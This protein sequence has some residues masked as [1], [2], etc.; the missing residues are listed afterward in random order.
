MSYPPSWARRTRR[1]TSI[2]LGLSLLTTPAVAQLCDPGAMPPAAVF[3]DTL[4]LPAPDWSLTPFYPVGG[5]HLDAV[6]NAYY[7]PQTEFTYFGLAA[8]FD[9]QEEDP[10]HYFLPEGWRTRDMITFEWTRPQGTQIL[11]EPLIRGGGVWVP[12][13][14]PGSAPGDTVLVTPQLQVYGSYTGDR[15]QLFV[16][17]YSSGARFMGDVVPS[18]SDPSVAAWTASSHTIGG[19]LWYDTPQYLMAIGDTLTVNTVLSWKE[20]YM[21]QPEFAYA[22]GDTALTGRFKLY[23]TYTRVAADSVRLLDTNIDCAYGLFPSAWYPNGQW[24]PESDPSAYGIYASFTPGVIGDGFRWRLVAEEFEGYLVWR[25]TVGSNEGWVNIWKIS[26]NEERDKQY[27]WWIGGEFS[28]S[29]PPP[30]YGYDPVTLTPVFGNTDER[31]YLDFDVH[32]GFEYSYAI[33]SFDRGFRP[34]SG[35]NDHYVASST[36]KENLDDVA[37]TLV[38]NRPAG[39]VLEKH[40]YCVPNPLRTGKSAFDDP[41]YHNFPGKV[42]RFVG[43][44]ANTRLKVYTVAGDLVFETENHDPNTRNVVWDTRNLAGEYVASGVYVYRCEGRGSDE[45]YGR[46]VII[47]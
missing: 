38:F 2:A 47:R 32:N 26:R 20:S 5:T 17:E 41:N 14:A 29:A 39:E 1:W 44:T 19:V 9:P 33:T 6:S 27:W 22:P 11:R 7:L 40:V 16:F 23:S 15:D 34:N 43:V 21:P 30:Y 46:L 24:D 31:L 42:V 13:P 4:L 8:E 18:P 35:E 25:K 12:D 28:P 36:A 3:A 45:E 37:E 10:P